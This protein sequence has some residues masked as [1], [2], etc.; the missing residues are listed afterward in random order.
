MM[1]YVYSVMWLIIAIIL[2]FMA[3]KEN[4][5]LLIFSVY[6]LFNAVWWFLSAATAYDMFH[7]TLGWVFRGVTL[8]FV[9]AGGIFYL[10]MKKKTE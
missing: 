10:S 7:G 1:S 5:I 2:V 8:V 4:K 9:I 6:F 3:I